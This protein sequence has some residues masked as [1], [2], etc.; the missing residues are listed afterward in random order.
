M[1]RALYL[2]YGID[3][4]NYISFLDVSPESSSR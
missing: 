4:A 1:K 3:R 2:F